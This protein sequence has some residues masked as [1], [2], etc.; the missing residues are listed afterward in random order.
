MLASTMAV[1]VA[2]EPS[3]VTMVSAPA[4][5]SEVTATEG[6][7]TAVARHVTGDEAEAW[8]LL[9][10]ADASLSCPPRHPLQRERG[11]HRE[12]DASA[13]V[14]I[15]QA[16]KEDHGGCGVDPRPFICLALPPLAARPR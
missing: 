2:E 4:L 12:R 7:L 13:C 10:H 5:V 1:A 8:C 3:A 6:L 9:I 16:F 15:H 14:R 11:T